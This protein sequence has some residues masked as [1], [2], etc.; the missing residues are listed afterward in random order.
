MG[1]TWGT[2]TPSWLSPV[3]LSHGYFTWLSDVDCANVSP[4]G[5]GALPAWLG[6]QGRAWRTAGRCS[7]ILELW[8]SGWSGRPSAAPVP[9]EGLAVLGPITY[10]LARARGTARGQRGLGLAGFS[11]CWADFP[12]F[13]SR[14]LRSTSLREI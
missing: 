14:T 9:A 6:S 4:T 7:L 1:D 13:L 2:I 10:L 3:T 5:A 8:R 12:S 11:L